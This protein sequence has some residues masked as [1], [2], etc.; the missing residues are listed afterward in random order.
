M[1][2]SRGLRWS[3]QTIGIGR[4]RIQP[5]TS[6]QFSST[7]AQHR[8]HGLLSKNRASL[9][10]TSYTALRFSQTNTLIRNA[11]GIRFASTTPLPAPTIA[12]NAS[13]TTEAASSAAAAAT[14]PEFAAE[15]STNFS[16]SLNNAT[17]FTS[18]SLYNIPEHIGYLHQM[19][20]DYGWGPTSVMQYILEHVHVYAGTPWW[21]SISLTA[22]AVRVLMFKPYIDA[23]EN[24]AR[25]QTIMPITKP[26]TTKMQEANR[27]GDHTQVMQL[28][29]E[30]QMINRR[31]GIKLW[32][33]AVPLMQVFVGYGTFV[34]LRAMSN[35]PVPGLETGG[36]LWL[37]NL[38][39]PDPYL[40]LPIATSAVLHWVLRKGGDTGAMNLSP[41]MTKAMIWGLP[42]VSA[43]F[44]WWLPAAVQISFFVS[45]VL[46]LIQSTLFRSSG[47]RTYFNMTPLPARKDPNA[48][49]PSPYRGDLKIAANPVLSRSE[50]NSRF[51]SADVEEKKRG[52][53]G[54]VASEIKGT[55][56]GVI[57]KGREKYDA[58]AE[59]NKAKAN[60]M[61]SRAYELKRQK[62]IEVERKAEE[63]R[64]RDER[65]ARYSR[66]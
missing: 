9:S 7:P 16:S 47:F 4:R 20:L 61:E 5:V 33:S 2:P 26:L 14:P 60:A 54:G 46:S 48:P 50:L 35:I 57:S 66:K 36:F 63:K 32:K 40:I 55:F 44:T 41:E 59:T 23:A 49:K 18:E 64:I 13:S 56:K 45:G 25:M 15:V 52:I 62:E 19:G 65:R 6:R 30:I 10:W 31:A 53:I 28:R 24:A 3:S 29:Q 12:S 17:D 22:I 34:L 42:A 37:Y 51:Q 39:I 43:L 38:S 21:V 8:A 11:A 1:I 58:S 27:A